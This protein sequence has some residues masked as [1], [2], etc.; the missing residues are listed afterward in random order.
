MAKILVLERDPVEAWRVQAELALGSKHEVVFED[1][2]K[3]ALRRLHDEAFDLVL[4]DW[5][6]VDGGWLCQK[7]RQHRA[8]RHIPVILTGPTA[9]VEDPK[10]IEHLLRT[11]Y[12]CHDF[13]FRP[14]DLEELAAL[15]DL[16]VCV[17]RTKAGSDR[18]S[19][20]TDDANGEA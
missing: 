14:F 2:P 12:G 5:A 20:D 11:R 10:S 16:Y 9:E 15:V 4:S 3:R 8:V 17:G 18:A 6:K 1:D 13:L 19:Q 7:V